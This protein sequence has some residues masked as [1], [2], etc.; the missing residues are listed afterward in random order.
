MAFLA[1][2]KTIKEARIS[3]EKGKNMTANLEQI[4]RLI[5][6]DAYEDGGN[7][8]GHPHSIEKDKD[9]I[10]EAINEII[11]NTI[12]EGLALSVYTPDFR[13]GKIKGK[14]ELIYQ[15]RGRLD[16]WAA[17]KKRGTKP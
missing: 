16:K 12:P 11:G 1:N 9:K 10:V 14:N 5:R 13:R 15:Q 17:P 8:A 4:I 6:E 2:K 3:S 7:G